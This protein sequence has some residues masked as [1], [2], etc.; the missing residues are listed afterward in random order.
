M[1]VFSGC[2]GLWNT[3]ANLEV[4]GTHCVPILLGQEGPLSLSMILGQGISLRVPGGSDYF[5]GS[6]AS[7]NSGIWADTHK[8]LS[9][10]IY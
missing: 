3:V 5:S 6:Q 4:A 8:G 2:L 7:N 9:L 10:S 1:M